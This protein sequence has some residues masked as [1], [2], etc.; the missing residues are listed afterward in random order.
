MGLVLGDK[1]LDDLPARLRRR[2]GRKATRAGNPRTASSSGRHSSG[3]PRLR[4]DTANTATSPNS[5]KSLLIISPIC[6][7]YHRPKNGQP[8]QHLETHHSGHLY[9]GKTRSKEDSCTSFQRIREKDSSPF[10]IPNSRQR[11]AV[12]SS[13]RGSSSTSRQRRGSSALHTHSARTHPRCGFLFGS[14]VLRLP[15][16]GQRPGIGF[17]HPVRSPARSYRRAASRGDRRSRGPALRRSRRPADGRRTNSGRCAL[18]L[19]GADSPTRIADTEQRPPLFQPGVERDEPRSVNLIAL[20]A[21]LGDLPHTRGIARDLSR[22]FGGERTP[23]FDSFGPRPP[24]RTR[25]RQP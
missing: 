10:P 7:R 12:I 23:Q 24:A 1:G 9:I 5:I 19:L 6:E 20:E 13:C 8:S 3:N 22:K 15:Q 16:P 11:A 18:P 21:V 4:H 14:V 2:R 17:R 25:C